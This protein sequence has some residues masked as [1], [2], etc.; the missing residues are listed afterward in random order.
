MRPPH[1]AAEVYRVPMHFTSPMWLHGSLRNYPTPPIPVQKG[2]VFTPADQP[3][4]N[5]TGAMRVA[6]VTAVSPAFK[7]S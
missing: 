6:P 7:K 3:V 5:I 2:V 1:S 4:A